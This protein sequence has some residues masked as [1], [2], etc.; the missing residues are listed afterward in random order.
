MNNTLRQ[1]ISLAIAIS[2]LIGCGSAE[3][4]QTA[5]SPFD[6]SLERSSAEARLSDARAEKNPRLRAN[7]VLDIAQDF[8]NRGLLAQS[9]STLQIIDPSYLSKSDTTDFQ[10]LRMEAALASNNISGLNDALTKVDLASAL[11]TTLSRQEK[12]VMLVSEAY[13]R[14]E[15]PLEAAVLLSDYEGVF[16]VREASNLNEKIWLLLQRTSTDTLINYRYFG[17]SPTT[18][19]WLELAADVK[20]NQASIDDQYRALTAW[21]ESNPDHPASDALPLELDMLARLPDTTP[22]R[23]VLALP[24]SGS[25]ANIG[26][27]IMDGFLANYYTH[28]QPESRQRIETFDTAKQN[29]A[30]LY[31]R[32]ELESELSLKTLVVGPVTKTELNALSNNEMIPITTLALNNSEEAAH[33]PSLYLFGLDPRQEMEQLAKG[34]REQGLQRIAIIAPEGDRNSELINHFAE[35]HS[36]TGGHIVAQ[37]KYGENRALASS[38]AQLLSTAKSSERGRQAR[39]ATRL[40]LETVPQ[41]RN[42]IDAILMLADHDTGKQIKPLLAFNFAKNIPVFATSSVHK[43]GQR[44]NNSD[45]SGVQFVDIPWVFTRS[46]PLRDQIEK[47]REEKSARYSRFYALGAD[48]F[49]LAPRLS[50]LREIPN[51]HVQGLTGKLNIKPNGEIMRELQWATYRRGKAS[52]IN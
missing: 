19:A 5:T 13:S 35:S 22:D 36:L 44:D 41:R 42:D 17:T 31:K 27:A 9:H 26:T 45:L 1:F 50:L 10:L 46:N 25:L 16:G 8:M 18:K 39:Q 14:L 43:I 21:L 40:K 20:L 2:M 38:V 30:N 12:I 37:A 47:A 28:R 7:L 24:L 6:S 15:Q 4:K 32:L 3:K 49:L 51:S 11:R 48:A 34:M 29:M 52:P 23:I 33:Q